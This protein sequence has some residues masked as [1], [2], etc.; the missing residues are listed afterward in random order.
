[1]YSHTI[2]LAIQNLTL[3]VNDNLELYHDDGQ[4]VEKIQP[5]I[6]FDKRSNISHIVMDILCMQCLVKLYLNV[7]G[8]N[9]PL[10]LA[11]K[12]AKALHPRRKAEHI[13]L[14]YR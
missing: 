2:D 14:Q 11:D 3:I 8:H 13:L 10:F 7:L 5:I 4:V 12:K 1:M 9:Y 6:H